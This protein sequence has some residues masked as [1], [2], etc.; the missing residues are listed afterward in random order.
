MSEDTVPAGGTSTLP[1]RILVVDDEASAR[2][3]VRSA[4]ELQ[5][6]GEVLCASDGRAALEVVAQ[7]PVTIVFLDLMMKG[8]S[9]QETLGELLRRQP[10]L[11]VVITTA[12][13]DVATAMACVKAGAADYLLKPLEPEQLAI[14]VQRLVELRDLRIENMRLRD[15]F[16]RGCPLSPSRFEEIITE[17]PG[18]R[19]LLAYVEAMAPGSNPMLITGDTGVGKELF[20]KALHMASG[21]TGSFVAVNVAGLDDQMLS[22]T[23]FGHERGAFTGAASRRAG[24]LEEAER[25]TLLLDEIGDLAPASQVKLLR[26]LQEREYFPAG[27][28]QPRRTT[29]SF[30]LATNHDLAQALADGRFRKDLYYR[31]CAHEIRIPPL[32]ERRKDIP[33]LAQRFIIRAAG[34][35]AVA[36]PQLT[37]EAVALLQSYDFPGNVRELKGLIDDVVGRHRGKVLGA[38]L[39]AERLRCAPSLAA[40]SHAASS[41]G[42]P[43]DVVFPEIMPTLGELSDLAM[44]EAL[45]RTG[46]NQTAA[47]RLLG[48]SQQAVSKRARK[49][50]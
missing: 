1:L 37:S 27:A 12:V 35:F 25:G 49:K 14:T 9:G 46:G 30:V 20:A 22:D 32:R 31:I 36:T 2:E 8:I 41:L 11:S 16:L 48:V 4:L 38:E 5:G 21:R 24:L 47:A 17:D 6:I 26:L 40:P 23:L 39:F 18:M 29:A 44:R 15:G 10:E 45:R 50:N 33:L 43:D 19:R 42:T 3:G 13:N 7:T 34:Q 28:D